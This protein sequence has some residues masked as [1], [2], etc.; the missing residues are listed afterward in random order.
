M[1]ADPVHHPWQ[2]VDEEGKRLSQKAGAE[3]G[4]VPGYRRLFTDV[5]ITGLC[6]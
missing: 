3:G 5:L 1:V 2:G 4:G 6:T